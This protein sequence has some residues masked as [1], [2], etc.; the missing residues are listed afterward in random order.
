[1]K[2]LMILLFFVQFLIIKSDMNF[3]SEGSFFKAKCEDDKAKTGACA[4]QI[5]DSKNDKEEYALFDKCG[6]GKTCDPYYGLCVK[7]L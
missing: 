3:E 6:K 4:Y 1:M 7:N 2:K 5:W